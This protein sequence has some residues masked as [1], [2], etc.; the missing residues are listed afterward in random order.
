MTILR[1]QLN[2]Y[3][4]TVVDLQRSITVLKVQNAQMKDELT[5]TT[6]LLQAESKKLQ[7]VHCDLENTSHNSADRAVMVQN[8][9]RK[10]L[11]ENEIIK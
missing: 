4:A 7:R 2:Q 6:N 10:L 3:S 1:R 5:R 9:L 8:D 11:E